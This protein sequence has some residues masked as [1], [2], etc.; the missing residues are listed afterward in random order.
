[1][2][3]C[4]VRSPDIICYPCLSQKGGDLRAY[5]FSERKARLVTSNFISRV[6]TMREGTAY[7]GYGN[8]CGAGGSGPVMD[9]IDGCCKEHDECYLVIDTLQGCMSVDTNFM[10]LFNERRQE[11]NCEFEV[12]T[13]RRRV[14]ECDL[15]LAQCLQ[16]NDVYYDRSLIQPKRLGRSLIDFIFGKK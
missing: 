2:K 3:E 16:V 14:C 5:G 13:C 15:D 12:E 8:Y 7:I 1:M 10:L 9:P 6:T 4:F 11:L